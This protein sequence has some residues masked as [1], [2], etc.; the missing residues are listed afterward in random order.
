[1]PRARGHRRFAT[2]TTPMSLRLISPH[3][4]AQEEA[5]G[6]FACTIVDVVVRRSKLSLEPDGVFKFHLDL[7]ILRLS[8]APLGLCRC[9]PEILLPR[10]ELRN[11][12]ARVHQLILRHTPTGCDPLQSVKPLFL[13]GQQL[14]ELIGAHVLRCD[15]NSGNA[16]L[17]H[18]PATAGAGNCC[19]PR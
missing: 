10:D 15:F 2:G 16:H 7:R 13:L 19:A 14:L 9:N 1:M 12:H 8:Q 11:I 17:S 18:R 6:N 3:A 5:R 4:I